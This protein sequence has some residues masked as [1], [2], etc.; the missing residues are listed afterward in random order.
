M[1]PK[2]KHLNFYDESCGTIH[3]IKLTFSEL[4]RLIARCPYRR[5]SDDGAKLFS[6]PS[7]EGNY[8]KMRKLG[9]IGPEKP[10]W[11]E[12]VF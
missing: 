7:W 2:L 4:H 12:G 11:E 8:R 1:I 10:M 6:V 5:M 3:T 9:K